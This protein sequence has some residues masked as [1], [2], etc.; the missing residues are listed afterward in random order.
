MMKEAVSGQLSA[1]SCPWSVVSCQ[2][3]LSP[4][5]RHFAQSGKRHETNNGQLTTDY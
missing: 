5:F 2:L 4:I 3:F 1:K